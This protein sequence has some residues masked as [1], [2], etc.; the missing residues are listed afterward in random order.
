M[1]WIIARRAPL[2][3]ALVVALAIALRLTLLFAQPRLSDDVYRYL[4][5]GSALASGHNPYTTPPHDPRIN[6]PEILTI[7]PPHAE[8]LF[9][10][11][12]QITLWRLLVIAVDIAALFL[13][14]E[15]A[16]AYA[17]FPP[18]L[19]EGAWNGHL[20]PIAAT[21]LLVAWRYESAVAAAVSSGLKIIPL[22]ALPS[23]V[24]RSKRRPRFLIVFT[25][26]LLVPAIPFVIAGPMM[27]GMK[28]YA[29]HWVFNSPLYD[30]AFGAVDSLQIAPHLKNTWTAVKDPLHLEAI[31]RFIYF[32]LY[33]D[34]LARCVLAVVA[35]ALIARF[36]RDPAAS[37]GALLVCSPTIHPWYWLVFAPFAS[38]TWLW[39][40]LC[41]PFSYLLYAGTSKW[42]VY[43]LCYAIPLL[44][45]LLPLSRRATS[46]AEW[47]SAAIRS[48]T[49]DGTSPQ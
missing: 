48:R 25:I 33:S 38:G 47:P 28:A 29:T 6:H 19:F 12:H 10:A 35:I 32:H 3:F 1:A 46:I 45:A 13:L 14:R 34:F 9:A 7:Y 27:P 49:T 21:L 22:A 30:I 4:W 43:A 37:I 11:V 8:L 16:L 40:A 15:G 42:L 20:E 23:L 36:R 17:T 26:V 44:I 41:A 18:L 24:I 39:L 2:P 31:S 5:D